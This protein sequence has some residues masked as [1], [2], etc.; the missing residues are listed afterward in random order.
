[1][2]KQTIQYTSPLDALVAVAKRLSLYEKQQKID[3]EEFFNQ[4]NQGLLSDDALFVEWAN[5]YR[6]Y[7]VLHQELAQRL[8]YAA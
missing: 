4:Y 5:D 1:M 2:R 6:H 7:L 8:N 3:S